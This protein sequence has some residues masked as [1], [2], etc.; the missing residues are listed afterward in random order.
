[1]STLRPWF[2][3]TFHSMRHRNVR[4][5][6]AGQVISDLGTWFQLVAIPWVILSG[7]GSTSSVGIAF[8][9]Q[10]APTVLF[11]AWGGVIA[12]RVNKR[13]VMFFDAAIAGTFS[14]TVGVALLAGS[15]HIWELFAL[16]FLTGCVKIF[17]DP[18]RRAFISEMVD[19]E[20]LT[21]ALSLNYAERNLARVISPSIAGLTIAILG[22]GWCFVINGASFLAVMIT[23]RLLNTESLRPAPPLARRKGQLREGFRYAWSVP[24]VRVALLMGV[25][26]GLLTAQ[27]NQV[28]VPVMARRVLDVGAGGLGVLMGLSGIGAVR[29]SLAS[30]SRARES[31]AVMSGAVA[32]MS[33]S[34]VGCA[35]AP[36]LVLECVALVPFSAAFMV[37]VTFCSSACQLSV[38]RDMQGR[39][40]ALSNMA[41][42]GTMPLGGLVAGFVMG[43]FGARAGMVQGAI[44]AGAAAAVA[45]PHLLGRR[46]ASVG[47][48]GPAPVSATE[49]VLRPQV[50]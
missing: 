40:S 26:I 13:V 25:F 3:D 44:G 34:L 36:D 7:T 35:V 29:G 48:V 15:V 12:D 23:L 16:S 14:L 18:A 17:D 9:L 46:R 37:F 6:F 33:L 39:V 43:Q 32:A 21:N 10:F 30:A 24:I 1:M 5:F 50:V 27:T 22:P 4:V 47:T 20:D 41:M 28:V 11:G 2:D 38:P 8:A 42:M 31:V 49:D 19:R 45:L